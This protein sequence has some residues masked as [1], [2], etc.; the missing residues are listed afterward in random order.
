[1]QTIEIQGEVRVVDGKGGARRARAAGKTPG[2]L[3]GSSGENLAIS[4]DSKQFEKILSK[5]SSGTFVLDLKLA[6]QEG[7][8]L[9]AIIKE[10]QR[11]P[12]SSQILHVDLLHVSLTQLITIQ[13]PVHL[14][15]TAVGVKQGGILEHFTRDIEIECQAGQI[16]DGLSIDITGINK[17]EMLHVS[18]LRAPEGV[19]ILTPADRVVVGVII[20][21]AEVE[22]APA[23]EAEAAPAA[24]EAAPAA[25]DAKGGKETAAKGG[26]EAPAKGAKEAPAKG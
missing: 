21:R 13:V 11:D 10:M 9:N 12:L 8:E 7:R 22:V 14:T 18:D 23:A 26:K 4:L 24:G 20:P 19:T 1:M 3:Y 25:S 6:G 15:G 17:G 2:V 5:H 16:P